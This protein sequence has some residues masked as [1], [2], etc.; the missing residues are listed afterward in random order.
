MSNY[1]KKTTIIKEKPELRDYS[2]SNNNIDDEYAEILNGMSIDKITELINR[3]PDY[4]YAKLI[5]AIKKEFKVKNVILGS[6]SEDLIIRINFVLN[7]RGTIGIFLPNFYRIMETAG[8]YI[9][10]YTPYKTDSKEIDLGNVFIDRRIKSIWISNPNPMIGKLHKKDQLV[11]LIK[12][13]NEILFV[14]DESAIDFIKDNENYSLI[15]FA[16]K[17]ENLIV[18]RS[19]SKL[20]GAAGL[21]VGFATGKAKSLKDINKLGLTFPVN[22]VAEYF[23]RMILKKKEIINDIRGRINN[24]K[25]I[26]EKLLSQN[27]NIIINESVSNCIFFKHKKINI[28]KELLGV[29]ILALRLDDQDGVREKGFVRLTIHSSKVSFSN[30]HNCLSK[31]L[32]KI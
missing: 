24:H 23:V 8:K 20:H 26:L 7:N 16:Q 22:G 21:R 29:N 28:F 25:L 31:L 9:K 14:V 15:G 27:K 1:L 19:F 13:Y 17:M 12:K 4:R 3:Y 30:L 10:I 11:R 32:D 6:G 18:I 2:L 5:E